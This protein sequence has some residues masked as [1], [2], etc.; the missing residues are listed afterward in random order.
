MAYKFYSFEEMC[1]CLIRSCHRRCAG[2]QN[3][4]VNRHF[5]AFAAIKTVANTNCAVIGARVRQCADATIIPNNRCHSDDKAIWS[6][7]KISIELKFGLIRAKL[8]L[9]NSFEDRPDITQRPKTLCLELVVFARVSG[10]TVLGRVPSSLHSGRWTNTV[11]TGNTREKRFFFWQQKRNLKD[12]GW[13]NR[14]KTVEGSDFNPVHYK[15]NASQFSFH[16]KID[17]LCCNRTA[18]H[19]P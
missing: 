12:D 13:T 15:K 17:R 9:A 1:F 3:I 16:S 11:W 4:Y 6:Q 14:I 5:M 8:A 19:G 2:T 18:K 10:W 7:F